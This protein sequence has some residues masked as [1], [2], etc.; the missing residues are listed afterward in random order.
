MDKNPFVTLECVKEQIDSAWVSLAQ[1]ANEQPREFRRRKHAFGSAAYHL[2][3]AGDAAGRLYQQLAKLLPAARALDEGEVTDSIIEAIGDG[4]EERHGL[5]A[6]TRANLHKIAT[7]LAHLWLSASYLKD[8][9]LPPPFTLYVYT[10]HLDWGKDLLTEKRI[11]ITVEV[12]S[13]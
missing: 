2:D 6:A 8:H 1:E 9:R 12:E 11:K 4:G 3:A 10:Q 5:D 13:A 7:A